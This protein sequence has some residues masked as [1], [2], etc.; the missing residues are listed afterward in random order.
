MK[1][2]S[3]QTKIM[4]YLNKLGAYN[5]KTISTNTAGTPDVLCC[6]KGHFL[7][8]EVKRPGGKVSEL[9]KHHLNRIKESGGIAVVAY[10][11]D[12]VRDALSEAGLI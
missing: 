3:I 1:E 7:A 9:Q 12:E 5:V 2:Q 11:I 6:F 10:G 4:A 8:V